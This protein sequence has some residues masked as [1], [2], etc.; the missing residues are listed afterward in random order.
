MK[1]LKDLVG[2]DPT[3]ILTG[4]QTGDALAALFAGSYAVVHPS[5]SEG[6]PIAVLEAMSYGKCVLASDIPENTELLE[7]QG[8]Q[9]MTGSVKDLA[10]HMAMMLEQPELVA[11][12][13]RDARAFVAKHYDWH[14]IGEQI[15][16]LYEALT[17]IP[18]LKEA[19][20]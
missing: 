15:S 4:L 2:S 6:L 18:N 20:S 10:D 11:A 5:E 9:F 12:V 3:I 17:Y 19:K 14:D 13:G 7:R 8:L 1:E 16:Y